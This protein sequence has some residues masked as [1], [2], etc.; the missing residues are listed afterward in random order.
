MEFSEDDCRGHPRREEAV[1]LLLGRFA[2]KAKLAAHNTSLVN[3]LFG[4]TAGE[5]WCHR[6]SRPF[7]KPHLPAYRV[8]VG[9]YG[10][11]CVSAACFRHVPPPRRGSASQAFTELLLLAVGNDHERL[12]FATA[13]VAAVKRSCALAGP[14]T[15]STRSSRGCAPTR[16]ACSSRRT[17]ST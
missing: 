17:T 15:P 3:R 1:A 10:G 6:A 12:G 4:L 14:A 13:T 11:E 7:G 5:P 2:Y 8:I 9:T 16:A